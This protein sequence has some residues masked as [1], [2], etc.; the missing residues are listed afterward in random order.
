MYEAARV[1]FELGPKRSLKA[2]AIQCQKHPSTVA[3]WSSRH[4][5]QARAQAYDDYRLMEKD[6]ER[7]RVLEEV[8]RAETR[9]WQE[10]R[11][12]GREE[13]WQ[14]AYG[15]LAKAREM[16]ACPLED[17]RWNWRDAAAMINQAAKLVRMVEARAE[18]QSKQD[19]SER[20]MTVRVEYADE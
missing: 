20:V 13:E 15:L 19:D 11:Q 17:A 12:V 5:W 16:L 4:N 8:E 14:A 3:R 1:Y 2:V 7:Q 9:T 10:R 6:E 18:E